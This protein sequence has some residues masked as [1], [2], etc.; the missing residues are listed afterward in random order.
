MMMLLHLFVSVTLFSAQDKRMTPEQQL[1]AEPALQAVFSR[2]FDPMPMAALIEALSKETGVGMSAGNKAADDMVILFVRDKSYAEVLLKL[3]EHFGFTWELQHAGKAKHYLLTQTSPAAAAEAKERDRL[4]LERIEKIRADA[5]KD[6]S[7]TTEQIEQRKA[8]LLEWYRRQPKESEPQPEDSPN[9]HRSPEWQAY[10]AWMSSEES[11]DQQRLKPDRL[12]IARVL[13]GLKDDVW[14]RLARGE[15]VSYH[16]APRLLQNRLT[17]SWLKDVQAW[18]AECDKPLPVGSDPQSPETRAARAVIPMVFRTPLG[19]EESNLPIASVGL[20]FQI[21]EPSINLFGAGITAKLNVALIAY[22]PDRRPI[23]TATYQFGVPTR[24]PRSQPDAI[25]PPKDYSEEPILGRHVTLPKVFTALASSDEGEL[26]AAARQFTRDMYEKGP[27]AAS[28]AALRKAIAD[29]AGCSL[30]CDAYQDLLVASLV[31]S[32]N[33]FAPPRPKVGDLLDL[34][35]K[36]DGQKWTIEDGWISMR[37]EDWQFQRNRTTPDWLVRKLVTFMRGE[38]PSLDELAKMASA[39]TPAQCR[40]LIPLQRYEVFGGSVGANS[41]IGQ[42]AL[43]VLRVWA[44]LPVAQRDALLSRAAIPYEVLSPGAKS[45]L[46]ALV[47][48]QP[49]GMTGGLAEFGYP[50]QWDREDGIASQ[51]QPGVSFDWTEYFPPTPHAPINLTAKLNTYESYYV[52]AYTYDGTLMYSSEPTPSS[53]RQMLRYYTKSNE[54]MTAMGTTFRFGK[55]IVESLLLNIH[56]GDR[57]TVTAA[58]RTSRQA[59]G[60]EFTRDALPDEVQRLL[61][62]PERPAE[63]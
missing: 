29:A 57:I 52:R 4:E 47:Q 26:R 25:P 11:E 10:E 1:S 32:M 8:K 50:F 54:D 55:F 35:E 28:V 22:D 3:A 12:A 48:L 6:A 7:I 53:A 20:V 37:T 38:R 30:I 9:W 45:A 39:L 36:R 40:G 23:R 58:A 21:E 15:T 42:K 2:D 51:Q 63:N 62:D 59:E 46:E 16:T 61:S 14:L 18:A 34:L 60:E 56:L 5:R 49:L 13:A 33:Q 27:L 41:I 44:E 24:F 43:H 19:R 17:A 31:R